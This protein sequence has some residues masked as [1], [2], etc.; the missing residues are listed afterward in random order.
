VVK[1][2]LTGGIGSGKSAA[3]AMLAALGAVV[4]DADALAREVVEPGTPGLAAVVKEFGAGVLAAGGGL[5][6]A[7]LADVVF[8]DAAALRRLEAIVHPL[9][10]ARTAELIAAAPEGSVVVYDTPLLVEGGQ[11]GGYDLVVVVDATEQ[12]RLARLAGRGLPPDQARSRMAAQAT[13]EQRLAV[14]DVV[15]DNEGSLTDLSRA[16]DALW[17]DLLAQAARRR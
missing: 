2:G 17:A 4:V 11:E 16:V 7:A 3:A 6:R 10:A 8:S 14:A 1:V 5:D 15:L 13:R 12:T 9:V